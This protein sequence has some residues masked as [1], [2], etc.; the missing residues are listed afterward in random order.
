MDGYELCKNVKS[1]ELTSHIPIILL[2]AKTS[3]ENQ[4]QGLEYGADDYIT[5]PFNSNILKLRIRNILEN[6]LQLAKKFSSALDVIPANIKISEIDHGFLEKMVKIIEDNIDD[7]DL[8][9]DRLA[10]DL[11]V[12]KGNLYKKLKALSGLTVNIFI[13]NIRLKT[14]AKLLKKGHY[15]ISEVAYAVGFN[16]PKYFSTCFSELFDMSPKEYMQN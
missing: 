12:S 16:N 6:R 2:T 1:N 8:N 5:K 3:E 7:S 10:Q 13:R 9:G 11:G 4:I 14:A 15:S